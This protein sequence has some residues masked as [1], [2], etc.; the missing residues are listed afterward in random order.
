[1]DL[2]LP[3]LQVSRTENSA[4]QMAGGP[5]LQMGCFLQY[6]GQILRD[7]FTG[8]VS[9]CG[10]ES[11]LRPHPRTLSDPAH[12]VLITWGSSQRTPHPVGAI[13]QQ[14]V[15]SPRSETVTSRSYQ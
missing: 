11:D 14:K 15:S 5:Q 2:E 8:P 10:E 13:R 3:S 7:Q 12:R 6:F 9:Y 4:G 1:M